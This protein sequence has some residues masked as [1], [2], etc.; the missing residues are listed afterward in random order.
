[1]SPPCDSP[2]SYGQSRSH[3]P[4]A[5]VLFS[6]RC[7]HPPSHSG[8]FG[9]Q[10]AVPSVAPPGGVFMPEALPVSCQQLFA[11]LHLSPASALR[12]V[13][14]QALPCCP[15][16][17]THPQRCW[18]C[19]ATHSQRHPGGLTPPAAFAAPVKLFSCM[20]TC[21]VPR[22][23][24]CM[25]LSSCRLVCRCSVCTALAVRFPLLLAHT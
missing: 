10:L 4:P 16:D 11:S 21:V 6:S 7:I 22:V 19:S 18:R 17:V 23:S 15:T 3:V 8:P 24:T 13:A 20:S 12:D 2:L 5:A 14:S 25:V 9:S 1:M